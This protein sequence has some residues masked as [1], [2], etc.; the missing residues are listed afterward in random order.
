MRRRMILSRRKKSHNLPPEYQEVEYLQSHAREYI[1]QP[2]TSKRGKNYTCTFEFTNYVSNNQIFGHLMS[3]ISGWFHVGQEYQVRKG[4]ARVGEYRNNPIIVSF[5]F[6]GVHT[7]TLN[8]SYI[9][10]DGVKKEGTD[11]GTYNYPVPLFCIYNGSYAQFG[12]CKMFEFVVDTNG[13]IEEHLIP[14][15]RKED[16]VAGMYDL[17]SG[18]FLTNSGSGTFE[19]GHNVY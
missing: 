18:N 12:Y 5:D 19:V 10:V 3:G 8:S 1:L 15:Y 14:C 6:D 13:V 9:V 4:Q 16:N 7:V 11:A 17:I 2:I